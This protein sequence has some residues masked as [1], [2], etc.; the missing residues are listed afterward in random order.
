VGDRRDSAA[1]GGPAAAA[2][3][4]GSPAEPAIGATIDGRY[5]IAA[6]IGA[7]GMAVVYRAHEQGLFSREVALKLL[8]PATAPEQA[9]IQRF[10]QEAQ[11]IAQVRHPNV[12]SL[13]HAGRTPEGQLY[14]A[15]E[16]LTGA[17]LSAEFAAL[18]ARGAAFAW[19]RLGPIALQICAAL[20]A[21]HRRGII[22]RDIKPGNV[23]LVR[24]D[25]GGPEF[26]KVLDFGIAKVL[27]LPSDAQ[28]GAVP[29]TQ[30]GM[31]LGTPHYAAPEVVEPADDLPIDGR[32][33]QFAVGVMLYQLLT[34]VLPFAGHPQV[35][36]LHKTAH[37]VPPSPRVRAPGR[38]IPPA[39]DALIMRAIALDPRDRFPSMTA[40]AEA[41]RATL[42]A[43]APPRSATAS[44]PI[45]PP[46]SD[47]ATPRSPGSATQSRT[48]AAT[49]TRRTIG[50]VAA[51]GAML[52]GVLAVGVGALR[53][54]R[55]DAT[56]DAAVH[57]GSAADAGADNRA[58]AEDGGAANAG[59]AA[60]GGGAAANGGSAASG[61]AA[62]GGSAGGGAEAAL[63]ASGGAVN[64][65]GA[66]EG[67]GD[68]GGAEAKGGSAAD[69]EVLVLD[70]EAGAAQKPGERARTI[71]RQF[72]GLARD[73]KVH[74]CLLK[75]VPLGVGVKTVLTGSA[76]VNPRGAVTLATIA[77]PKQLPA[78][79]RLCVER[80]IEQAR[81]A[82]GAEPRLVVPVRLEVE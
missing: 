55:S 72:R 3:V 1:R 45:A 71:A 21:A 31:F 15:M 17:T 65:G 54:V 47:E 81:V 28:R 79:V 13:Y 24:D 49:R 30:E 56:T 73:A 57:G 46:I 6:R 76:T 60:S 62:N 51:T 77:T 66:P 75:H 82:A 27:P 58:K 5:T 7:G 37:E 12:I 41:I 33:D 69:D 48:I 38:D 2:D 8:A 50:L 32:A 39:V 11:A 42:G 68:S 52:V 9:A 10:L 63:A 61:V 4:A 70:D 67:A 64:E 26:V 23:F 18:S 20:Q 16:L 29:L 59:S 14:L 80:R 43:G 78:S 74:A 25:D 40:L 34:G 35:V 36:V 44:Q 19:D 22:H 53:L